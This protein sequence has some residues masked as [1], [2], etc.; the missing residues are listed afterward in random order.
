MLKYWSSSA[1]SCNWDSKNL[2][3]TDQRVR[4][5][6]RR[7]DDMI[8]TLYIHTSI[9]EM[10]LV[11]P[12]MQWSRLDW[13]SRVR[14]LLLTGVFWNESM[15]WT[16]PNIPREISQRVAAWI[17]S[18]ETCRFCTF[19]DRGTFVWR[20]D[21]RL[22]RAMFELQGCTLS[23]SFWINLSFVHRSFFVVLIAEEYD[24]KVASRWSDVALILFS[25]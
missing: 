23:Y 4:L 10:E 12:L 24:A 15:H 19:R 8:D 18:D 25:S 6:D 9:L 20:E 17:L 2:Q 16:K 14:T 21:D 22:V 11:Q 7:T 5:I 1:K 13:Y 3:G